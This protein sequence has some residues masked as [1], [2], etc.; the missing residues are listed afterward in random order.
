MQQRRVFSR[1]GPCGIEKKK[2]S[3]LMHT[4][5]FN[6]AIL[7]CNSSLARFLLSF[8]TGVSLDA[9]SVKNKTPLKPFILSQAVNSMHIKC[10]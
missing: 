3:N 7:R 5:T 9:V 2:Q 4:I 8:F 10:E 6:E 1:R